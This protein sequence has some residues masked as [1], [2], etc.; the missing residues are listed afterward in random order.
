MTRIM[1]VDPGD[2]RIGLA[3]SDETRMIARPLEVVVHRSRAEDVNAILKIAQ[4]EQVDEMVVG[5]PY[6]LG[7]EPGH[8]AR[9]ALRLVHALQA[10]SD[11]KIHTWD[12]TGSSQAASG[13]E[14]KRP[15]DALA[16]AVILQ[17]FL[18]AKNP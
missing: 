9:K 7:P 3:I 15:I 5:I 11:I 10:A 1:G 2:V 13:L 6:G 16:A 18:D 8:Q 12:E 17:E 4:A 14:S